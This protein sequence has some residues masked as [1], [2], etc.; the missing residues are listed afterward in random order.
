[1]RSCSPEILD[2]TFRGKRVAIVGSGPGV[3]DN[4]PG[5]ID[6]FD[7]VVRVN[8]YKLTEETGYR[9]DVFYSF[10]G[11]SI[12]KTRKDLIADGVKLCICKCPDAKFMESEWHRKPNGV[13][14]RYI[15]RARSEW[16]FCPTYVPALAEFFEM[17]ERLDRH[18]PTTGFSAFLKVRQHAPAH[19]FLTGFDFFASGVHNVDEPWNRGNPDDPIGHAPA[20]ERAWL[21]QNCAGVSFDL[22]LAQIMASI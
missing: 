6:G 3:L 8:N 10:F 20:L 13:D 12:G 19:V 14:F 21:A 5:Y 2:Q 16:W 18:I 17:F 1:M 22:R 4:P 11:G 15:Y 9:T 7:I